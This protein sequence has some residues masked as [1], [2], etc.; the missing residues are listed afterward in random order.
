MAAARGFN[1]IGICGTAPYA[2]LVGHRF[3]DDFSDP[4]DS[5]ALTRNY[6]LVD[7]Y[8]NSWGPYDDV[9][10]MGPGELV[11]NALE[12]G[13]TNGRGGLGNIY[14]WAGGNGG[15][16]DDNSNY[17]GYANSRYTIAV[18]AST[19]NG[20][21]PS[22]SEKGANILVNAPCGDSKGITTTDLTGSRG[23]SLENYRTDFGGTSAA[24]P[25]VAGIVALMLQ[26]NPN[27]TWRDVQRV[28]IE[29]AEKN[30]SND[31]DWTTNGAGYHMNHKYGFG[32]VDAQAAVNAAVSGTSLGPERW[33]R[34]SV[35][36]NLPIPDNNSTGV[37][38]TINIPHDIKV[39]FVEVYFTAADHDYWDD[40]EVTLFSPDGTESVLAETHSGPNDCW[41]DNWRFGSVR[42]FGESSRGKWS[43][44]VRDLVGGDTGTFQFWSLRIWGSDVFMRGDID[45]ND[46]IELTD[47]V[48][49]L[50]VLVGLEPST[51]VHKE[52]DVNG[53]NKI[54]LEEA[55]YAL[56]EV[57]ELRNHRPALHLIISDLSFPSSV[58]QD[59]M[60]DGSVAYTETYVGAY[61]YIANPVM[62]LR[63]F[64]ETG[65]T[66][67]Y[68]F[69][70]APTVSDGRINFTTRIPGDI[71]GI[72][73]A[74]FR[75]VDYD[76]SVSDN[77]ANRAVS[78]ILSQ[79]VT[80]Q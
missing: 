24:A 41:Y 42:H 27:L 39:E 46:T 26:A 37:T 65:S 21:W 77:W 79:S 48:L 16:V 6:D 53:D 4:T 78:N 17:D 33:I 51:T 40:L 61:D 30:D 70:P 20:D 2:G 58:R 49:A 73:V 13:V 68:R 8:S 34:G 35:S 62:A 47:A 3:L 57:A 44:R 59:E 10:L 15:E 18:A 54:G 5:L 14:V 75:F 1:E 74:Y 36:P 45:D 63:F 64:V 38:S 69:K 7:I 66:T 29:T 11:Q 12:S 76:N 31:G 43:L 28:L 55:L 80:I 72:G 52:A 25:Q 32:R 60:V 71:S 23:A 19:E 56:Q 67:I 9:R 50:Q 22:Y